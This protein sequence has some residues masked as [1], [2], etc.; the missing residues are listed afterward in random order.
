VKW[1]RCARR[2]SWHYPSFITYFIII[3][4]ETE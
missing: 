3:Q 4:Q 2:G 1:K